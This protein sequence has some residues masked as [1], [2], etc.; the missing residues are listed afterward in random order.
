M[1]T[2]PPTREI[3]GQATIILLAAPKAVDYYGHIGF[4][5]HHQAWMLAPNEPLGKAEN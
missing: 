2:D 1:R 3:G 5:R 4:T